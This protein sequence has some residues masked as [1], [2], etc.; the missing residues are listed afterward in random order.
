MRAWVAI[1]AALPLLAA[2]A[3]HAQMRGLI[4]AEVDG[5]AKT[6]ALD[7]RVSEQHYAGRPA[8]LVEG[9]LVRHN[10]ATNAV[11]GLGLATMYGRR[12]VGSS[13]RLGDPPARSRKPAVSF[14]L[15][16]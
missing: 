16:F 5:V 11:V 3:A 10:L 2:T 8:P 6:R 14:Q 1:A 7:L 13:Y 9:L 15:K 12:K 4:P